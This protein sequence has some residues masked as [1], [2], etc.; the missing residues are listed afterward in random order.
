VHAATDALFSGRAATAPVPTTRVGVL[1]AAG[2]GVPHLRT[3]VGGV[4]GARVAVVQDDGDQRRLAELAEHA[5]ADVVRHPE[6]LLDGDVD[7][8]VVAGG[9]PVPVLFSCLERG[10]PAYLESGRTLDPD[11][12]R[13][14]VSLEE[15][16]GRRNVQ[17]GLVRRHDPAHLALRRALLDGTV[18][19]V[20][21]LRAT[22][23][24]P[25]HRAGLVASLDAVAWLL[26]E[27][28][29]E[30][31]LESDEPA[32]VTVRTAGVL[33]RVEVDDRTSGGHQLDCTVLGSAGTAGLPAPPAVHRRTPGRS[34]TLL[35]PD[36]TA[37]FADATRV[38]LTAWVRSVRTGH[39]LGASAWDLH[40]ATTA[41]AAVA[42]SRA[43]GDAVVVDPGPRPGLYDAVPHRAL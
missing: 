11:D 40:V 6:Q 7:A 2:A 29:V 24:G 25:G 17:V 23:R 10:L 33:A 38:A 36:A 18:G 9:D 15:A 34:T 30:V 12:V 35:P 39:A 21:L 3:L 8:V 1:G 27:A 16:T 42:T 19:R 32:L 28:P 4:P 5:E 26:G 22:E 37:R 31:R 13:A 20:R 41:A 14:L 43:T